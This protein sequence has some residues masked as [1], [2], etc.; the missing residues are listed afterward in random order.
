MIKTEIIGK[1]TYGIVFSGKMSDKDET[2]IAV[3]K[4]IIDSDISFSGCLREL[5]LLIKLRGHPYIIKLLSVSF[6]SPFG[7]I[8][9]EIS[10]TET[11]ED[12]I[13]FIFEKGERD[14]HKLIQD[15]NIHISYLKLAMV[16]ILLAVEYMHSKGI[17][18][19]D[20]KP[21]NLICFMKGEKI[22]VKLC[23]FGLSKIYNKQ[24]ASSPNLV[25]C[26]YRAPEICAK[27]EDYSFASDLWSVG[28]IFYEMITKSALLIGL[29]DDNEQILNKISLLMPNLSEGEKTALFVKNGENNNKKSKIEIGTDYNEVI[30]LNNN[31]TWRE[32]IYLNAEK[33]GEF[34]MY[35]PSGENTS[36][37]NNFL[38]LL[39]GLLKIL[40]E[41][42][43]TA[44]QALNH[45]FFTPYKEIINWCRENYPPCTNSDPI[46]QIHDCKERK[47]ATRLAFIVF[48]N[49]ERLHWYKDRIIFQSIDIFDRYL[50]YLNEQIKNGKKSEGTETDYTGKFLSRYD[51][52]LKYLVC[53]YMAIKYFSVLIVPISFKELTTT[54]YKTPKAL[55]Q[56]EEFEKFLLRDVLKFRIYRQTVFDICTTKLS[57][58]NIRD[59]LH[60]YG[61]STSKQTQLSL[62]LEEFLN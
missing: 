16:H 5:D 32:K 28:C 33:I 10:N 8:Q 38:N 15:K 45:S 35:P 6:G 2:Q 36:T 22:Y 29:K 17:I 21:A 42:R 48:N 18:H 31:K 53:L 52:E 50:I 3:K 34:D 25:T 62:L 49:R 57:P 44:T 37:F 61:T 4:N 20:I 11:R 12:Y 47:W 26:W 19:R 14:L 1:G 51:T 54:E 40:P 43:L 27:R 9:T 55:I 13:H 7:D 56:A 46:I 39:E 24:E 41:E 58:H 30:N 60:L 59:L 23:D